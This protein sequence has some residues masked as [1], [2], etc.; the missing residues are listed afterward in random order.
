MLI[1]NV[2]EVEPTPVSTPGV[3]GVRMTVMV[4]RSDGA[5]NFAVRQFEIEPGGHTPRHSHD[6]EHEVYVVAGAGAF[7]LD[8]ERRPIKPGDVIY[9]PA[10][11]E[12][13]FQADQSEGLRFLCMTPL[14]GE[15]GAE[16][17]GT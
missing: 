6:Y 4:G 16:V 1:R 3:E 15:C 2:N 11:R 9:V 14:S 10:H 7:L 5:P 13:Q 17:P 12:H 8:G